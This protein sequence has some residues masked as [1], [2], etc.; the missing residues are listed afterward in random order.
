MH[1]VTWT[2]FFNVFLPAVFFSE[3]NKKALR[4]LDPNDK[5]PP[6]T[7]WFFPTS[8]DHYTKRMTVWEQIFLI[9]LVP[10]SI[11]T[12]LGWFSLTVGPGPLGWIMRL[13]IQHG[14]SNVFIP[15]YVFNQLQIIKLLVGA[16]LLAFEYQSAI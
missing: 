16:E 9:N 15:I 8:R 3:L 4:E 12:I 7:E 11:T 5:F 1:G 10:F 6:L 2:S 14:L 13:W